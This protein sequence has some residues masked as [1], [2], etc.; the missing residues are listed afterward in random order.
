MARPVTDAQVR[1]VIPGTTIS[2]LTPFITAANILV[3]DLAASG[4]GSGLSST[5]LENVEIWLSAHFAAVTDPTIAITEQKVE[6]ATIKAARG[7][8]SLTGIL[9]TQYGVMANTLS[10]GCLE[11]L[12]KRKPTLA[13]A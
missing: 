6:G 4:C 2:V 11:E 9:S 7:N 3:D 10:G 12:D 1:A 5:R 13:F 8:T